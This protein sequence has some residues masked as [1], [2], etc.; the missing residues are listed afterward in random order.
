MG[1]DLQGKRYQ[2]RCLLEVG[3]KKYLNGKCEISVDWSDGK[4]T[5]FSIGTALTDARRS[6]YFAYVNEINEG[7]EG[8]WNGVGGASHA[9]E[10]LGLMKRQGEA[11]WVNSTSKVCG[12][13]D[14][15]TERPDF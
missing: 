10:S 5:S 15:N 8:F 1:G 9:Q 14:Y 2:G 12:W 13:V 4:I 3:G 7:M 11:C 6:K